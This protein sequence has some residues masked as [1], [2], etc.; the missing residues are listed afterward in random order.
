MRRRGA[1]IGQ[2]MPA[3]A[4]ALDGVSAAGHGSRSAARDPGGP[5]GAHS[6]TR[7]PAPHARDHAVPTSNSPTNT[8]SVG[9]ASRSVTRWSR[10]RGVPK[11]VDSHS[12][13]VVALETTCCV[14]P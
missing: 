10:W 12:E 13:I 7:H 8:R 2:G 5:Q 9:S 4:A 11:P 14:W 1:A 6:F 3:A